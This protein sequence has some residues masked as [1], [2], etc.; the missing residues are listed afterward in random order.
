MAEAHFKLGLAFEYSEQNEDAIDQVQMAMEAL[1][2]R[3]EE[4]NTENDPK[5]KAPQVT[6]DAVETTELQGFLDEMQSKLQDLTALVEK[7]DLGE[8]I[9]TTTPSV[10]NDISGLV[11][12]RKVEAVSVPD[13]KKQPKI[14]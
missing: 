1:K 3:I 6:V 5:G 2:T 12:K 11:K 8:Q 9:K 10:V 4:L 7:E 14:D 13:S